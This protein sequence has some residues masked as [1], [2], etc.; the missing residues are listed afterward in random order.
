VTYDAKRAD[1]QEVAQAFDML[2]REGAARGALEEGGVTSVG[3]S[4]I[5]PHGFEVPLGIEPQG[6][7]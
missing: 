6:D 1:E 4:V 5:Q 7:Y 3:F 2:V